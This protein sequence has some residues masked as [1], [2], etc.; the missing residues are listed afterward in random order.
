MDIPET[1][2][3]P[4]ITD[5]KKSNK[6]PLIVLVVA[7]ILGLGGG[8]Y[9]YVMIYQPS[10]F[11][12]DF[13]GFYK[14]FQD[15]GSVMNDR[16][17][18]DNRDFNGALDILIK[19]KY[20]ITQKRDELMAIRPPWFNKEMQEVQVAFSMFLE[21]YLVAN[22]DSEDKAM[23]LANAMELL[24][25][26]E[27]VRLQSRG[28]VPTPTV[29]AAIAPLDSI[30][31]RAKAIGKNLFENEIQS[32][33]PKLAGESS[34]EQLRSL[35][36]GAVQGI[37]A[38]LA[39]AKTL[40][41]NASVQE[42]D[43]A[44]RAGRVPDGALINKFDEFLQKLES[45]TYDNNAHDLLSYRAYP[46]LMSGVAIKQRFPGVEATLKEILEENK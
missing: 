34:F 35:W 27:P 40:N 37:D 10:Q 4:V 15:S 36:I 44:I 21:Q 13:S 41:Q 6:K 38:V 11:G 9:W 26:F 7:I 20:V 43:D 22:A 29:G 45:A 42:L 16:N 33:P 31:P 2:N 19:R 25:V 8:G 1:I 24:E 5:V 32:Q 30:M 17:I 14:D 23:F 3:T 12:K 28:P 39:Y 18:K 46:D